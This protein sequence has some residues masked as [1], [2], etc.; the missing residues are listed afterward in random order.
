VAVAVLVALIPAAN[1]FGRHRDEIHRAAQMAALDVPLV[2]VD[3]P[4]Y[5][6]VYAGI[7]LDEAGGRWLYLE[8][9]PVGVD[10]RSRRVTAELFRRPDGALDCDA[11]RGSL[12]SARQWQC[13][14]QATIGGHSTAAKGRRQPWSS[15]AT[16]TSCSGRRTVAG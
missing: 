16:R 13:T 2:L 6:P 4:G 14:R 5:R 8:L 10:D 3:L 12:G 15:T 1:A 9:A 7:D 11:V